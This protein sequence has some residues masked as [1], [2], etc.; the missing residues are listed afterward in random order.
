MGKNFLGLAPGSKLI[1]GLP[2]AVL[3]E[4]WNLSSRIELF[5]NRDMSKFSL[6]HIFPLILS[7]TRQ[8]TERLVE[9]GSAK[10]IST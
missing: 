9:V 1:V 4:S 3:I 2:W 6:F 5:N 10:G 8:S 7:D